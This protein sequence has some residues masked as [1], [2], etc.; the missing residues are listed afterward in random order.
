MSIE[1]NQAILLGINSA[2]P[3]INIAARKAAQFTAMCAAGQISGAELI[4]LLQ[5]QQR[6]TAI[7]QEINDLAALESLNTA[8]NALITIAQSV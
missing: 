8:I 7:Y 5:D 4:E 3:D 2:D 6:Q 1:E